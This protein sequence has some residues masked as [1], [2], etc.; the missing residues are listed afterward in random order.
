MFAANKTFNHMTNRISKIISA[1]SFAVSIFII[2]SYSQVSQNLILT[3]FEEATLDGWDSFD[4]DGDGNAWSQFNDQQY[5]RTGSK[6]VA[7][8]FNPNGNND[9]LWSPVFVLP[10]NATGAALVFYAKS[11]D[12]N[13]PESFQVRYATGSNEYLLGFQTAVPGTYQAYAYDLSPYIGTGGWIKIKCNSVD[14]WF[15]CIDDFSVTATF[16]N[17][18]V[19]ENDL[20]EMSIFP[21]PTSDFIKISLPIQST[22]QLEILDMY[23]NT[24]TKQSISGDMHHIDISSLSAG[25]YV[26]N[27]KANGNMYVKRILKR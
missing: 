17:A 27:V 5:A 15:L 13:Y 21:N 10:S 6:F 7:V 16:N 20:V 9:D 18:S 23:G 4:L 26:V 12:P 3:S 1:L 8:K 25:M 19:A 22:G 14:K 2:P 24:V 11:L